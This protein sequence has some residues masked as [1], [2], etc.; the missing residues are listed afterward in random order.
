[1]AASD[2]FIEFLRDQFALLGPIA[3]RRMFGVTGLFCEGVMFGVMAEDALYLR[4]DDHNRA[5]FR[6][7]K[8]YPP[9][10]Y[11]KQGRTIDLSF[12]R[13]P[14]RLFDEPDELIGWARAGLAA[15]HRVAATGSRP[16]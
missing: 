10:S 6:E 16:R 5:A 13:V 1:M 14:D 12:W 11:E 9:L 8:A 7:A 3:T 15:A 2:G 4:V